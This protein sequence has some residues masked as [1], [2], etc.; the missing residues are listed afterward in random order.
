MQR[1]IGT[2]IL[3]FLSMGLSIGQYT[4]TGKVKNDNGEGLIGASIFITDS[5]FATISDFDGSY[6]I[7][8]VPSDNIT[9]KCSYIGYNSQSLTLLLDGD[10]VYNIMMEG[11]MYNLDEIQINATT[12]LDISSP[13]SYHEYSKPEINLKNLGQDLPFLLEHS[14]SVVVTSDAGAGIGYTGMRIR[15]S[16]PT[17]VNVTINGVPLNDSES[18]GVFWVNLPDFGSSTGKIQV[19]RG[20]GPS[21][22]G[23]GAFGATVGLNTTES[24]VNPFL[25]VDGT[26]GSYGTRKMS[27]SFG[28][29]LMNN[30]Y[31]IEGRYSNIESDG[32]VDRATSDLTSWFFS[33]AKI[34][35]KSSLRLNAFSGKERTYQS[36]WGVPES[37]LS[38]SESE[39]QAHI[40]R[41]FYSPSE[42][43]NLLTSDRTY[44][45]YTY[46]NQ[47]DDYRQSHFQALYALKASDKLTLNAT[48]HYTRGEGFF[49]ESKPGSDLLDYGFTMESFIDDLIQQR[50]LD[51]HFYGAIFNAE[52]DFSDNIVVTGG[53]AWNKYD[54]KH[55][56]DVIRTDSFNLSSVD[57][58]YYFSDGSKTDF[59]QFIKLNYALSPKLTW[60]AD[61]QH[62][63]I[64]Y[65][66]AGTDNDGQA[67][68]VDTTYNFISPKLGL[69]YKLSETSSVYV[70]VAQANR[71]PVRS[72]FVDAVGTDVPEHEELIDYEL[73]YRGG[74]NKLKWNTN[75]Y[76]MDYKNQLVLSG[77]V[78]DVGAGVRVNVDDSYRL[79]IELSL[80][81]QITDKLKWTPNLTLSKNKIKEFE[82]V[83]VDFVSEEAPPI[84]IQHNDTDITLSPSIISGSQLTYGLTDEL[85]V[86]WLSKYVGKQY[87]N[88]TSD[89]SKTIDAYWVNDLMF[90]YS[91]STEFISK[92][93][94][95]LL[96]NNVFSTVYESNGYT[97]NYAFDG[98]VTSENFYYPQ[99][100]FNVLAGLSIR[101]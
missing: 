50:W 8:N 51:N 78:N 20:V 96:L 87:L 18:H 36:W 52:Y 61:I 89:E 62:R 67:I 40:D 34:S 13:F 14:P 70:S 27:V 26:Y 35:N 42:I 82:E 81:Y 10:R 1:I 30:Q 37:K 19:Q 77:A 28:T 6:V 33:V 46:E 32:Y 63:G 68:N 22:V 45:F 47:V 91:L 66:T 76:Y 23:A 2:I 97:F 31:S 73:G 65:N 38:G 90:N 53:T 84:L 58:Q 80:D 75:L 95:K 21:S 57:P 74:S 9:I 15:G 11:S 93:E 5:D 7:E 4:I 88:N 94:F 25:Q 100:R 16:D 24:S 99:A 44:N 43:S 39:L 71:E 60:Q 79:G 56:G 59:S 64:D 29:G 48:G 86:T 55:F 49:E 3:L 69:N 12:S 92:V 83:I 72:D 54:G 85:N 98:A 17:R 101:F 41:N